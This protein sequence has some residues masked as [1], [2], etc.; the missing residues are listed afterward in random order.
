MANTYKP[1]ARNFVNFDDY[2]AQN[3][4]S[5]L[6]QS[7]TGALGKKAG[8][9]QSDI[10]NA[11]TGFTAKA[12]G[13]TGG[14]VTQAQPGAAYNLVAHTATDEA[15]AKRIVNTGYSGPRTLA[16]AMGRD[17]S[18][19]VGDVSSRVKGLGSAAGRM[20]LLQD[21]QKNQP[22]YTRGLAAYDAALLGGSQQGQKAIGKLQEDFGGL[23]DFLG[24]AQ[25]QTGET[26]K[27]VEGIMQGVQ[28]SARDYLARPK[29]APKVDETSQEARQART[30][31]ADTELRTNYAINQTPGD[32]RIQNVGDEQAA[33]R[34]G[35]KILNE[36]IAAG[37]PEFSGWIRT[38]KK[39]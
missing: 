6:V 17:V 31:A 3:D 2:L 32:E 18:N 38:K 24:K 25:K 19:E 26:A 12:V 5:G 21:Q 23:N 34:Y 22:G 20:T 29:P 33:S 1:V 36:W 15:D 37:R 7:A 27:E 28:G 39:K 35:D 10:Q 9:L 4:P 11:Q 14:T 30:D 16:E 13:G 8:Q